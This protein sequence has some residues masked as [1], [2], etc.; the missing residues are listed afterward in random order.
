MDIA[1]QIARYEAGELDHEEYIELFQHLLDTGVV[2]HLQGHYQRE[3]QSL[4]NAGLLVDR[5]A[6]NF[7]GDIIR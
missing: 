6:D 5:D 7:V 4:L 2:W 1:T 3:T